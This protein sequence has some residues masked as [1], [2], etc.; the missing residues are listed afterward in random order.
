MNHA[1]RIFMLGYL[2]GFGLIETQTLLFR[3]YPPLM[4][5]GLIGVFVIFVKTARCARQHWQELREEG[6]ELSLG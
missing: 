4:W 5:L 6:V 2:I 3:Q 1:T